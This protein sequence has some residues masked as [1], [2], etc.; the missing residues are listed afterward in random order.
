MKRF[1]KLFDN[2]AACDFAGWC[3]TQLTDVEQ[4]TNGL[5]DAKHKPKFDV[6]KIRSVLEKNYKN[7]Y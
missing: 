5:L 2:V 3:Y 7:F 1:E 6:R 4:E